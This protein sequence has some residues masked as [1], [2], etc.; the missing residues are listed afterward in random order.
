MASEIRVVQ[1]GLGPIGAGIARLARERAGVALVG[2]IDIDPEK[3]G[4]DAGEVIGAGQS[5]GVTVG[6]DA[7]AVLAQ[8]RPDLVL[9]TTSSSLQAVKNQ[10]LDCVRAGANVI[11]TCEEL[12]FPF[13]DT[14]ATAEEID[15]AASEQ[16]VTVLGAGVNPGFV[17]DALPIAFTAACRTIRSIAIT[18]VVDASHRRLPLQRKIGA[19][20]TAEE[21]REQA[22]A[23]KIRHVGLAE[24]LQMVAAALGWQLDDWDEWIGPVIAEQEVRTQY[25]TVPA[26]QVAGV[27]QRANGRVGGREVVSLE[28]RMYVGARDPQDGVT[29]DGEPPLKLVIPGGIHGD[30]ATAA[31]VVNSIPR[32]LQ[33]GAG[34]VTMKDLPLVHYWPGDSR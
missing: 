20:M 18:R 29:I 26:G 34:L 13:G 17:M 22:A 1:Y 28:L 16:G 8:A 14:A 12:S 4:R 24:S 27:H 5:L 7:R 2:A 32:V 10:I 31:I 30:V 9:H 23:K 15:R 19:G 6:S 3:V 21:F 11:S 33:S 25:L